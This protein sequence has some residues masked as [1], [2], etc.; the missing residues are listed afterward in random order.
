VL[1][2]LSG[3]KGNVSH[4]L[5]LPSSR[6][7]A[8]AESKL[9]NRD[10]IS[11]DSTNQMIVWDALNGQQVSTFIHPETNR[12]VLDI[13][14][15]K[16][17]ADLWART[18]VYILYSG[19]FL[20][21]FD[22]AHS[23]FQN[24]AIV[25]PALDTLGMSDQLMRITMDP[26]YA[27]PA[28]NC[29]AFLAWDH[30]AVS[31]VSICSQW[32]YVRD[33]RIVIH[34][35]VMLSESYNKGL[36]GNNN[37]GGGGANIQTGITRS[38]SGGN[39][40]PSLQMDGDRIKRQSASS[41]SIRKLVSDIIVGPDYNSSPTHVPSILN[42]SISFHPGMKDTILVTN[43]VA[44]YLINIQFMMVL[45]TFHIEKMGSPIVQVVPTKLR[46]CIVTLHEN[47]TICLRKY[48][49]TGTHNATFLLESV[50]SSENPRFSGK[51]TEVFG[52]AIHP[53]EEN[54]VIMYLNDGRLLKYEV[55]GEEK[56]QKMHDA[57]KHLTTPSTP[58]VRNLGFDEPTTPGPEAISKPSHSPMKS[59]NL[60]NLVKP[61]LESDLDT[62]VKLKLKRVTNTF[63]QFTCLKS[64]DDILIAGTSMGFLI[65][66]KIIND[67]LRAL[68]KF[69]THSSSPISGIEFVSDC[70]ILT[71]S[72][73]NFSTN[74]KCE[75]ILTE[76]WTGASRVLKTDDNY[77]IQDVK[78]SPLCQYFV[79]AYKVYARMTLKYYYCHSNDNNRIYILFS[80][81]VAEWKWP[82]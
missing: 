44:I 15:P 27:N 24:V 72:N 32:D 9:S 34:G 14:I 53:V 60:H 3:H 38:T 48:Y 82:L 68:K 23:S 75:L 76:I 58:Y 69:T 47:G 42:G 7:F 57:K 59:S 28:T 64:R 62:A 19:N 36:G 11:V 77:H 67:K 13:C 71:Y 52:C 26:H 20:V 65:V 33:S 61:I 54:S 1:Q 56:G 29:I 17:G 81:Y 21:I 45:H 2:V 39:L 73:L 35:R 80:S 43:D 63:G 66:L 55:S 51:K 50:C 25:N 4:V 41:A 18:K 79:I 30:G 37:G 5:W 74:P 8:G 49:I 40:S 78:V 22:H 31:S 10:V 6:Q 70:E 12:Q 16:N 46:P